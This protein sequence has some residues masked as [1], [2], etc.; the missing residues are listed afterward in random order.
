MYELKSYRYTFFIQAYRKGI[1]AA[2]LAKIN[3]HNDE[4]ARGEHPWKMAVN[5]LADLTHDE[6]MEM[7]TLRVPDMP[8]APKKYNMQA[9]SMATNVDWRDEVNSFMFHIFMYLYRTNKQT[10][11]YIFLNTFLSFRDTLQL[12]KIKNHADPAGLSEL[13][14]QWKLLTLRNTDQLSK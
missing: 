13:S 10:I 6:F 14:L 2:N 4:Y 3:Q 11:Q 7:Q 8:K 12:L 9:K 1:F 5:H